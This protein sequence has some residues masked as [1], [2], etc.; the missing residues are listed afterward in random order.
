MENKKV[1]IGNLDFAVTDEE[2]KTLFSDYGTVVNIKM[3]KKK[4][5]AF[6]EMSDEAEAALAIEKLNGAMFKDREVRISLE[7]KANKAKALSIKK[8]NERVQGFSRQKRNENP[9][10]G[11]QNET[12]HDSVKAESDEQSSEFEDRSAD[13]YKKN[14]SNAPRPKK[15][16]PAAQRTADS[17]HPQRKEWSYDRPPRLS[18]PSHDGQKSGYGRSPRPEKSY[19]SRERFSKSDDRPAR[20]YSQGRSDYPH[21][22]RKVWSDDNPEHSNRPSRDGRKPG[23]GRSPQSET[24]YNSRERFSKSDDRPARNHSQRRFNAPHPQ[25]KEWSDDKPARNHSQG[26]FNS[27]HPQSKEWSDDKPA[28]SQRPPRDGKKP[29]YGRSSKPETNYNSR[30]RFSGPDDRPA[31]NSSRVR[32]DFPHPQRKEWSHDKPSYSHRPSGPSRQPGGRTGDVSK[33]RQ[34]G[35]KSRPGGK[36]SS[37]KSARPQARGGAGNRDRISRPKR[38]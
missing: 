22:Q 7:M 34:A 11:P 15:N 2:L 38:D 1:F 12:D 32:S 18:G 16:R 36:N 13:E 29:G 30:E 9:D 33:P 19:N 23:Y 17:P 24:N 31:R 5:C 25:R 20:N 6:I 4:G 8:Y 37:E 10:S 26:R 21:P 35:P 27:P 14:S 28:Y 3:H